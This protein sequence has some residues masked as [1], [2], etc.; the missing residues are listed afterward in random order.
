MDQYPQVKKGRNFEILK[1][2]RSDNVYCCYVFH[3]IWNQKSVCVKK[4]EFCK[5]GGESGSTG[6]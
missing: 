1:E 6:G 3:Y 5:C 4:S 2:E